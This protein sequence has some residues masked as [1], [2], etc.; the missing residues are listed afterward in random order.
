MSSVPAVPKDSGSAS[1]T[2]KVTKK[3]C[4]SSNPETK[5][6]TSPPASKKARVEAKPKMAKAK[7]GPA[8]TACRKKKTKCA[9]RL[10]LGPVTKQTAS[11]FSVINALMKLSP[12]VN[13]SL[14]EK[15]ITS[16]N[17]NL[18]TKL[19][20][21]TKQTPASA[22]PS[23]TTT[24]LSPSS[25]QVPDPNNT[26]GPANGTN[27]PK[28]KSPPAPKQI[29]K[30]DKNG[31]AT[32]AYRKRIWEDRQGCT[33]QFTVEDWKRQ[34]KWASRVFGGFT[35]GDDLSLHPSS[36]KITTEIENSSAGN[37]PSLSFGAMKSRTGSDI[38]TPQSSVKSFAQNELGFRFKE[39]TASVLDRSVER[40]VR[41]HEIPL[42]SV[43]RAWL[44]KTESWK[45]EAKALIHDG[46]PTFEDWGKSCS[47]VIG[48]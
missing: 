29:R 18:S 34:P 9:H 41:C 44:Q 48:G 8:C 1:A 45:D 46:N 23:R 35:S 24:S 15:P 38:D 32:P 42:S 36:S 22:D 11:T 43:E 12:S 4:V 40:S 7:K 47:G 31:D 16:T 28:R 39:Q 5:G 19:P 2:S 26:N 14:S 37:T 33:I 13:P 20:R 25:T 6:A 30:L 3:R 21:S 27:P 10:E 17:P